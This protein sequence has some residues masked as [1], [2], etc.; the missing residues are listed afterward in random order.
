MQHGFLMSWLMGSKVQ[1]FSIYLLN[2]F[3]FEKG[4]TL[5]TMEGY[6]KLC[7]A[8]N[9]SLQTCED[10]CK[11]DSFFCDLQFPKHVSVALDKPTG[12]DVI[13]GMLAANFKTT[14]KGWGQN[15]NEKNICH[16][17]TKN[18]PSL[19]TYCIYNIWVFPKIGV[20]KNGWFIMENPI[21]M[22]DLGVPLF[23]ETAR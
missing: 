8:G 13:L 21:K 6:Y 1:G 16:R 20:S 15:F 11:T 18:V 4:Q 23:L 7:W 10:C 17:R 14:R 12:G 2:G 19:S 9:S 22:D 3:T 5:Q